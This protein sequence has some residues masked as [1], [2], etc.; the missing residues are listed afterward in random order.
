M[1][2]QSDIE[3]LYRMQFKIWLKHLDLTVYIGSLWTV[4]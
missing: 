4:A 3:L 1:S 2:S